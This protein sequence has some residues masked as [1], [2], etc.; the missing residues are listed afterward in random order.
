MLR[1]ALLL[2]ALP[3]LPACE[4]WHLSI[5][6]DGLVLV[7]VIGDGAGRGGRYRLRTRDADGVTRTLDVPA[8]GTVTLTPPADGELEVAL[9]VPDGCRVSGPNPQT[10]TLS[11]GQAE[12]VSF[13]ARCR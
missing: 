8:S 3:Y 9:L 12:R 5:N 10:L 11:G 6:R 4:E 7:S 2:A 1:A 13:E